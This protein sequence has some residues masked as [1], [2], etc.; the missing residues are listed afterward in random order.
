[1]E[2]AQLS[3]EWLEDERLDRNWTQE[4][5]AERIGVDPATVRRWESGVHKPRSRQ[6][7]QLCKLFGKEQEVRSLHAQ[8]EV[9]TSREERKILLLTNSSNEEI[10]AYTRFQK[11]DLTI[12]L[13][14][15]VG[16]WTIRN[17]NARY[18]EL[19]PLLMQELEQKDNNMQENAMSRRDALRRL[20]SL[21]I[22]MCGLSLLRPILVRSEEEILA[23][24]AAGITACW[25]L[26]K[27]KD[28][29]F[30]SDTIS[31]YIPT[32]KEIAR[33]GS[34]TQC[35][36]AAE[37]LA[38]SF[39]LKSTL[40]WHISTSNA[41]SHAQTAEQYAQAA[42]NMLLQIVALR[43]QAA[44]LCYAN[45]WDQALHTAEK[46]KYLLETTRGIPIPQQVHSY[47]YAG[48]AT[49][50]AYHG[51][52]QDALTSLRKAHTAFFAPQLA[53]EVVPIWI[54]HSI[55]N[56]LI[57]DG[58]THYHLGQHKAALDSYNQI[59][60]QHAN[61]S[62]IPEACY[63]ESL[64]NQVMA[65]VDR[66]DQP[67]DMERSITLWVQGIEGAKTLQSDQR[68]NEAVVAYTAMRAVWPGEQRVRKLREYII[69]W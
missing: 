44:A 49:Y 26:R 50:Q 31:R 63:V 27:G 45:S 42:Q 20:A 55:G 40:A 1:M 37:L 56:L 17:V 18:H 65:E 30:A 43:T 68:F 15:L 4:Y 39:L 67:R 64:V 61:D 34:A 6:Y 46:A 11:S 9:Q 54:D 51:H 7:R 23:Q 69:H 5:V 10:D 59:S 58:L 28:L 41:V 16:M 38:Q 33:I 53:N 66:D 48:L 22:E 24:C 60:E 32:L 2:R 25:Y 12:R 47:V 35:K 3:V 29:A 62:T 52:K 13:E 19:Q 36:D 8:E 14:H 57:N 21:P